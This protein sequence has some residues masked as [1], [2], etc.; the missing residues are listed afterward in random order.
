MNDDEKEEA[1]EWAKSQKTKRVSIDIPERTPDEEPITE[2][3]IGYIMRLA[4]NLDEEEVK[5]L[6]K[7]QA[8]SVIDQ[9]KSQ[10]DI[11]TDEMIDKY[12]KEKSRGCLGALIIFMGFLSGLL[13]CGSQFRGEI[14]TQGSCYG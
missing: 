7:W 5:T 3:Q 1:L 10:Q 8:S 11:F 2:K 9:I 13:Y 4:P 12:Q 6:G 14:I